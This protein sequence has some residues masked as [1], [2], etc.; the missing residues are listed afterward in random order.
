MK[1]ATSLGKLFQNCIRC[2]VL[3]C[4]FV[5][6]EE[7]EGSLEPQ[8]DKSTCRNKCVCSHR[9][10]EC[11]IRKYSTYLIPASCCGY[12]Q[13]SSG[14][15]AEVSKWHPSRY[16][17]NHR[18]FHTSVCSANTFFALLSHYILKATPFPWYLKL[19][20]SS[21]NR[22]CYEVFE[23]LKQSL[24]RPV[25]DILGFQKNGI[26][27]SPYNWQKMVVK[28]SALG[29]GLLYPQEIFLV[30]TSVRGWVDTRA[31]VQP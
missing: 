10:T 9:L 29:T 18:T 8:T 13:R 11:S 23:K 16:Y 17:W 28:R 27:R 19:Q 22:T 6:F 2:T 21:N 24:H 30:L 25:T 14:P 15:A 3:T 1:T 5:D 4:V 31:I 12:H 20:I 26:S 7:S